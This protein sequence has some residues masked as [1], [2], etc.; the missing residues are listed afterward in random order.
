MGLSGLPRSE[1]KALLSFAWDFLSSYVCPVVRAGDRVRDGWMPPCH[2]WDTPER[3]LGT[4]SGMCVLTAHSIDASRPHM[5]GR[6]PGAS[7][8]GWQV[9]L[10]CACLPPSTLPVT[11]PGITSPSRCS[12]Q[13]PGPGHG[14][15]QL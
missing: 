14:T 7:S 6:S 4:V 3:P 2:Q 1:R 9:C 13:C 8:T 11:T 12:W 15:C 5:L 10:F